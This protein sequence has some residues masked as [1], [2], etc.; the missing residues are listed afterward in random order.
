MADELILIV[1]DNDKLREGL[2]DLLEL[3][4]FRVITAIHGLDALEKMKATTPNLIVADISMPVMDGFEFYKAVRENPSNVAIPFIFL[5]ARI[6]KNDILASKKLGVEDYLIKPVDYHEFITTIRSRLERSQQLMLVQLEQA[7]KAT[8]ILMA[9][10]IELRDQY[11]RG[12]VERVMQYS[13]LIA[14]QLHCTQ[15]EIAAIQFGALLHDIGKIYIQAG[16][17]SK[18]GPLDSDEWLQMKM[19][20]NFGADLLR[21]IPYLSHAVPVIRYHHERW[22]GQGYPDGI[23]SADIPLV[24]RI[25]S[26]ADS[27]DAMTS[28]RIYQKAVS[29]D[30][31]ILELQ[32]DSGSKYD[33]GVVE[34][35]LKVLRDGKAHGA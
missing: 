34:A 22:D 10:A 33:P 30:E 9:N 20:T 29:E 23:A 11:T 1:E 28:G 4:N 13:V 14:Q 21:N 16:T 6:E 5:T 18:A 24:A 26:V 12:H 19:H 35:F 27:F 2:K 17:L 15:E 31:A 25:V 32:K 7:Y 3:E 8:L